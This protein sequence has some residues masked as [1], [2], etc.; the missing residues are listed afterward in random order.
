[1]NLARGSQMMA[2][3]GV[4]VAERDREPRQHGR[5]LHRQDRYAD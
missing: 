4:L 2:H 1:V 3:H 5:A